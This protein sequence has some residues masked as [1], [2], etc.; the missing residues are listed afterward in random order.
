MIFIGTCAEGWDIAGTVVS[1]GGVLD[2]VVSV[3]VDD[4]TSY[5]FMDG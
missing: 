5:I 1:D 3:G 4:S 2:D